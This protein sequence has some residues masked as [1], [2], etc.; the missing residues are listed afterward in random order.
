[1]SERTQIL[2]WDYNQLSLPGHR[3]AAHVHKLPV[4]GLNYTYLFSDSRNSH[5]LRNGIEKLINSNKVLKASCR[6]A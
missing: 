1:M 5:V 2:L 6:K 4:P 3:D